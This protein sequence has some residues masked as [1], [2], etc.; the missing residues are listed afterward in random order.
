M[1]ENRIVLLA[2]LCALSAVASLTFAFLRP[3]LALLLFPA[4]LFLG[5]CGAGWNGVMAAAL[6]E[7]GGADRA[8]SALGLTLTAIFAA[9]A[10]GPLFFGTVADHTSLPTAWA[11][12][13]VAGALG[14]LP[15]LW[16]RAHE[17]RVARQAI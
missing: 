14:I 8:G 5:F 13:A 17:R 11:V 9:S 10:V 12:N 6:A 16:L 2:V 4:A 15:V 7:I 1:R 3:Q